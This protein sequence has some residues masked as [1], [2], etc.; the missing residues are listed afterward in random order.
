VAV[1]TVGWTLFQW[2]A[3]V[4][5][6][7]GMPPLLSGSLLAAVLGLVGLAVWR[8]VGAAATAPRPLPGRVVPLGLPLAAGSRDPAVHRHGTAGATPPADRR[9]A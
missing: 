1:W 9:A 7:V 4:G 3:V 6:P 8:D 2:W 5:W